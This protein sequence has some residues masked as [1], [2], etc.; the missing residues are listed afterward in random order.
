MRH[1]KLLTILITVIAVLALPV[2][3]KKKA[4]KPL[5]QMAILLDTSGSMEGLIEQAK[6][7]LWK[8]VNEMALAKQGGVSPQLEV[9]LYEYGKDSIPASENYLRMLV[10]LSTDLDKL[11]EELFK[12][13][14]NGGSEYC[15]T[16]IREASQGL[17]WSESNN[18][19]KIIF[20]AGNEPFTQGR[21][22]YRDACKAAIGKG[23][24]VNTIFC[25]NYQQGVRT[26]W[27]DGADLADGK[28][29]NIDHN[30]KLVHVAAPQDKEL[31]ELGKKM[32][33][34]YIGYGSLRTKGKARQEMQDKNASTVSPS[35]MAQ[36]SAAKASAQYKNAAW[37]LV[38]ASK[39]GKVKV[40]EMDEEELPQEMK[41]MS[42]AER[43]T[44]VDKKNKERQVIQERIRKLKKQRD[45]YV[46][47]QRKKNAG[48]QTLDEAVVN[49]VRSQAKKK[50][51]KFE[52][53]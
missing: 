28:Y 35:V 51:F 29:I 31:I 5:I 13:R 4:P 43:R 40:E 14:T 20:I 22:H 10:P 16:V 15:G 24:I 26:H 9:A 44:F 34:T 6:T 41:K 8:I 18:H 37:D 46:A 42:K 7:Q 17:K 21:I 11:S 48:E 23:I 50:K 2:A 33:Q 27:K 30:Q 47:E 19:L 32:N 53:N 49:A 36:R 39:E 25:G 3:A 38:D 1:L 45:K 52:K 12:L